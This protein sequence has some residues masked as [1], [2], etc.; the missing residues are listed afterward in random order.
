MRA[1]HPLAAALLAMA[2]L[3]GMDALTKAATA[4]LG[5]WQIVALR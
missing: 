2:L 4:A 1:A 3:S 5:T